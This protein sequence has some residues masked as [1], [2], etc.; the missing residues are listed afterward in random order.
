MIMIEIIK[1]VTIAF[2]HTYTHTIKHT[3]PLP[4]P[5]PIPQQHLPPPPP[6]PSPPPS[7]PSKDSW[8]EW[9]PPINYN[10]E[11]YDGDSS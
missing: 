9:L 1:I 2:V 11:D 6:P 4:L 7:R 10:E 8:P 5:M 3:L